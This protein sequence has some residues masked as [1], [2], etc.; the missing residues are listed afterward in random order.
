MSSGVIV[1][2]L[3]FAAIYGYTALACARGLGHTAPWVVGVA[4]AVATVAALAVILMNLEREF[5]RWISAALAG[6][7]LVAIVLEGLTPLLVVDP[8]A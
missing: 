5:T 3:H 4:T 6:A 2:G 1:W 7:A 8:C